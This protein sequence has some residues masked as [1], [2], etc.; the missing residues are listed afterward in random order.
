[1][2]LVVRRHSV[3]LSSGEEAI[4]G[5]NVPTSADAVAVLTS[6]VVLSIPFFA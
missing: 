1:V 6:G 2:T 5:T 3:V 4:V